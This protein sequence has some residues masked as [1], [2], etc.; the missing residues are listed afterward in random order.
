MTGRLNSSVSDN[1]AATTTEQW[2]GQVQSTFN[3]LNGAD[4]SSQLNTFYNSWSSLANNPSDPGLRQVVLQDGKAVASTFQTLQGQLSGIQGSVSTSLGSQVISADGL[5]AQIAS[6]NG[7][8]VTAQ[9]GTGGTA[10]ALLDQ[11]DA[12]VKSLSKLMNVTTV[13]QPS[14]AL[15]VYVGS[16]PLVA[17][18]QSNGVAE[19][20]QIVNG[21]A[22]QV[23]IFKSNKETIPVTSG[24]IG[25][26]E[27]VGGQISGVQDQLNSLANNFIFQLNKIHSSGQGTN[28]FT[29]VTS[30]SVVADPTQALNS[31]AAGLKFTPTNGSFVVHVKDTATGLEKSTLVQVNLTGQPT[32][33]TLN[34][35]AASLAGIPGVSATIS[36]GRLTVAAS[37]SGQQITFSQ[38]SSGTLAALGINTFFSGDNASN[39]A[40]NSVLASS[41]TLIA[42]AQ[43]G[44][45]GDNQT[46]LAIAALG[47]QPIPTLQGASLNDTYQSMINGISVSTAAAKTNAQAAQTIQDTLQSQRDATSGVSVDEETVNLLQQQT[48]YQAAAKLIS[49]TDAMMQT[50]M[51]MVQ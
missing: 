21:K 41:P 20:T 18:T 13:Q 49:V 40:V 27:S 51:G 16:E 43:N 6:L 9:G 30:T 45:V 50:L 8:I 33:T 35:L 47:S 28:G 37:N 34:S 29:S 32:D 2:L 25:A 38:D 14:G 48:A 7:Q 12:A 10:N 23:A 26:L 11:R 46:A 31:A 36:G 1:Q 3:A 24:Q 22:T 19:A 44:D 5:A 39:I 15:D 42:A 4:L 17:G